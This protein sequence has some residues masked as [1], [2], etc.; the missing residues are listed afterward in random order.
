ANPTWL[1]GR[2]FPAGSMG[3]K[4]EAAYN[5]AETTGRRAV[6]GG[7]GNLGALR[8]GTAGTTVARQIDG[9]EWAAS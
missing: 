5:F 3:P 2:S 6:I 7:L 1:R 8:H 4:V 9:V